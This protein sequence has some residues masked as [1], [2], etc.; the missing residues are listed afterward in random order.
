VAHSCHLSDALHG[1]DCDSSRANI[2]MPSWPGFSTRLAG[3][4]S[5][6]V[7]PNLMKKLTPESFIYSIAVEVGAVA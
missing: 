4:S 2:A 6:N 5:G 1:E 3:D 7:V